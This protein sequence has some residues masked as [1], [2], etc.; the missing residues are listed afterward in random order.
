MKEN[1]SF[2]SSTYISFGKDSEKEAGAL[3][4]R[5]GGSRALVHYGGGSI[6]RNGI[7]SKVEA[8]LRESDLPYSLLGGVRP[9]PLTGLI[10]Q[11]IALCRQENID[12]IL[13]VGGGSAIDS[14]KAIALGAC[15][16]GDVWDFFSKGL[17][18]K[19]AL[20][21]GAIPTVAA[22]GSEAS[23]NVVITREEGMLKR[24]TK[25]DV[26]R[27]RFAIMNPA[28]TCTLP[29]Y[30]TASGITDIISHVV[31]RYFTRTRNVETSDRLCE[32]LF[33]A[34]IHEA[35]RVMENPYDYEARAN[36]MWA[37]MLAHNDVAGA[38][39]LQDWGS[40]ALEHELSA[41]YGVPHGAGLAVILPA[42]MEYMLKEDIPRFAQFAVR[43]WDCDMDF[44]CPE[45]TA[46]EGIARF[47][48]FLTSI[49]MPLSFEELG[50]DPADIPLLVKTLG[51]GLGR[52]VGGFKQI[53]EKDAEA[54][55]R[56]ACRKA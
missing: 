41:M 39:R 25:S 56:L 27:P 40:H 17:P 9:N 45:R 11:G 34:V 43:V 12:F 31:E 20:P 30:Q 47:R 2:Y 28:F 15:Y 49:G 35:P 44:T 50:A 4:R 24:S 21:L 7:L 22:A 33:K 48:T 6:V 38:D 36:I 46:R 23:Q 26:L 8:S 53:D 3:V 14:A 16:E 37:G 54:I 42:W 5:F 55:Y 32:A 1:F 13:A 52:Q 29:A 18:I 10:Y 19:S 51:V